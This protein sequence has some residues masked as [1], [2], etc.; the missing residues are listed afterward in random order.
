[1]FAHVVAA[2][3]DW[4]L[5]EFSLLRLEAIEDGCCLAPQLGQSAR[6]LHVVLP[7]GFSL[8]YHGDWIPRVSFPS[9]P[10]R[11]TMAFYDLALEAT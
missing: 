2:M 6:Y 4:W 1:M 3:S 11:N 7:C 5:L 10:D 9:G 8:S